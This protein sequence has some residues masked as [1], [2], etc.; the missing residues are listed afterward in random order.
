MVC[1]RPKS[2]A[3]C[4]AFLF[5]ALLLV[6]PVLAQPRTVWYGAQQAPVFEL[7]EVVVPGRRPQLITTTPASVT[8]ITRQDLER[9]GV[10]TLA[11]ALRLVPELTVRVYGGAGSLV[12]PSI[13]G[14][15]PGQVLVL[16]DGVPLN[17]V[18]LG[19][20]DLSTISIDG[21]ERIEVL[22]GP[23]GAIHGSGALGGVIN[24]VLTA[25]GRRE[26]QV[27][28]GGYGERSVHAAAGQAGAWQIA[29]TAEGADG[30]RPNSDY[31][32]FTAMG[33][34][35]LSPVG[36]ILIH[37]Y[38]ADLGTPGDISAPTP[39]DRQAER[40][41]VVQVEWGKAQGQG[42][43]GRIYY[44]GDYLT[45]SSPFGGSVYASTLLGGEMQRVWP[46]GPGRSVTGG[47]EWQRMALD[48]TVFGSAINQQ[49]TVGA[50][51]LEYDAAVSSKA[52][53]SLGARL[54]AHST[55]GTTVNPR[56]GIVY[57]LDD[58][59]RLRAAVGRT[60]RGPTFLYLFFPG[61]SNAALRPEVAWAAE[62]GVERQVGSALVTSTAFG[63]EVTDLITGGCPPQN[64]GAASIRGVSAE[65]RGAFSRQV[66]GVINVMALQAV[67]R[68]S[69]AA[70]LRV[71]GLVA[72]AALSYQARPSALFTVLA[73]YVG[74]RSDTD[75][76]TVPAT[77]VQLPPY[78][79]VQLRYQ[80]TTPT[81]WVVTLGI[82]N[83]LDASYEVVKGFPVPGRSFFITAAKRY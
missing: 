47:I 21:V 25:A 75:F 67:D 56:A 1:L 8:V 43:H 49:T 46:V 69:G 50:A 82:S 23:F 9:F 45:F 40:R 81:G 38:R 42:P 27:R 33:K 15:G 60:F 83:A 59:T 24:I 7:P 19:Q 58:R 12:D 35:Q 36:R 39:S 70:L 20:A 80:L 17:S 32:G 22:R 6:S 48:A 71:P 37:H 66:S 31:A 57:Q 76:S 26:V 62:A 18:A 3:R 11:E 51:Y 74:S 63:A 55:Y 78:V 65:V 34:F 77:T 72:H 16:L 79:D 54:D 41:T 68:M 13:R 44:V 61:C 14:S 53:V 52:L 5:F 4:W 64:V 10:R 28:A 73:E 30:Y 29:I 2:A